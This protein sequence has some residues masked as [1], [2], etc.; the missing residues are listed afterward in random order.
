[1]CAHLLVQRGQLDLDAPVTRYWPEFGAEG[2]Q[3]IPVRYLLSHQAG[4]PGIDAQLTFEQVC[5][6][7]PVIRALEA[8]RP[9]WTP[10]TQHLYHAATYGYLVGEVVRRVSGKSLGTYFHDEFAVPLGLS[11]WIGL[12]EEMEPRVAK[13]D[14]IP[15]SSPDALVNDF[16]ATMGMDVPTAGRLVNAMWG[17]NSVLAR[18]GSLNGAFSNPQNWESRAYRAAEIPAGNMCIDAYSLA[19]WY[20]AS[21]SE[22]DGV[23]TLQDD[24]VARATVLQTDRSRIHGVPD[25]LLPYTRNLFNMSLGFWRASPPLMPLLGPA[26]FG[27]PGSGGSLGAADPESR[28]AFGY[29]PN[30]A[31]TVLIDTRAF[32]LTAAVRQC[33]G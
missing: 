7:G 4:L 3:D 12:P 10:G 15:P 1:M 29:V 17:P 32:D 31:P 11:A 33:L 27:H 26:S 2:K 14:R 23:R 20:A 28:V 22:V 25:D 5:A 18:A 16:A 13:V 9:L 6:W 24:T 21:V 30:R 8:Q 19:R